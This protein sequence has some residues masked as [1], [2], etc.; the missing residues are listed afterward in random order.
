MNREKKQNRKRSQAL[1]GAFLAAGLAAMSAQAQQI[2]WGLTLVNI[3]NPITPILATNANG[4]L[5]ITAGGGDT[6]S[7]PDS[8][9]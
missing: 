2:K 5:S 3:N 6:Y 7:A 9:T 8:F 1:A 4:S